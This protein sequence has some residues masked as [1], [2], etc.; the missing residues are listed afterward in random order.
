MTIAKYK[1]LITVTRDSFDSTMKANHNV[2]TSDDFDR[3]NSIIEAL[4]DEIAFVYCIL[5][6]NPAARCWSRV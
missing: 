4:D 1:Q 2:F 5:H 6:T 3:F